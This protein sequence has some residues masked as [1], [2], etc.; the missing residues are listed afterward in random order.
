MHKNTHS[1]THTADVVDT[2]QVFMRMA[3][4]HT[5]ILLSYKTK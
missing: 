5:H 4:L 1:H 3:L 2:D